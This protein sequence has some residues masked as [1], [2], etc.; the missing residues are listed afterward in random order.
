MYA[1]LP[2]TPWSLSCTLT[3]RSLSCIPAAA[4]VLCLSLLLLPPWT[5]SFLVDLLLS[6]SYHSV[7]PAALC[8]SL[9]QEGLC[10]PICFYLHGRPASNTIQYSLTLKFYDTPCLVLTAVS[11]AAA[12]YLHLTPWS[13]SCISAAAPVLC[14]SLLLLPPW[15]SSFLV[16]LLLS[17][18]YHSVAPAAC[19]Y[20]CCRRV[21]VCLSAFTSK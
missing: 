10:L 20:L 5:S 19:V 3:P 12:A 7:A 6:L 8:L 16:D 18:S 2:L 4:P 14:L 11:A 1:Y 9:Q 13:L 21:C 15:T 17:L